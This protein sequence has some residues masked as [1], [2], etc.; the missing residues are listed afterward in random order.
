M[1]ICSLFVFI[2]VVCVCLSSLFVFVGVYSVFTLARS[3]LFALPGVHF[4]RCLCIAGVFGLTLGVDR[5]MCSA[6]VPLAPSWG[7]GGGCWHSSPPFKSHG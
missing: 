1:F 7:G 6:A 2:F 3:V 5:P 4:R